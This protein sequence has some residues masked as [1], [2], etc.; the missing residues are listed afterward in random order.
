[1]KY[2]LFSLAILFSLNGLSAQNNELITMPELAQKISYLSDKYEGIRNQKN[3]MLLKHQPGSKEIKDIDARL[4]EQGKVNYAAA[5]KIIDANG[6][7]NHDMIGEEAAHK[8]WMM[9]QKMDNH[10]DFQMQV[11]RNMAEEVDRG[12]ASWVDFA[13]LTDRVLVNQL[14]PQHYGT[15]VYYDEDEKTYKP[16]PLDDLTRTN[17]RRIELGL[18][19][20]D[21]FIASTNNKYKGTIQ[22][23]PVKK[24]GQFERVQS[25]DAPGGFRTVRNY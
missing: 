19:L 8:F 1:M 3:E 4:E 20:L 10:P 18:P 25:A 9:I 22:R 2:I 11:L 12:K 14:R 17:E 7:P 23:E 21:D 5:K 15:Q 16:H 13:Y 6:F 24:A